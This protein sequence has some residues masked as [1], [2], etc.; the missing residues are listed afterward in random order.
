V[1]KKRSQKGKNKANKGGQNKKKQKLIE[2]PKEIG[3][4]GQEKKVPKKPIK[5]KP[6]NYYEILIKTFLSK[7]SSRHLRFVLLLYL[8]YF[9]LWRNGARI[10]ILA[11]MDCFNF[12]QIKNIYMLKPVTLTNLIW[13]SKNLQ[14]NQQPKKA[15]YSRNW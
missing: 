6:H 14:S 5:P 11:N 1:K 8:K 9:H 12:S 4:E 10:L 15:C 7:K 13:K 3:E 2:M